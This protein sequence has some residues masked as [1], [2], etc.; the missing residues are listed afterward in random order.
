[1]G[2]VLR[3]VL[4]MMGTQP[5]VQTSFDNFEGI[6]QNTSWKM[7]SQSTPWVKYTE[8][9]VAERIIQVLLYAGS[10]TFLQ[11]MNYTTIVMNP[12]FLIAQ[13][14]NEGLVTY[15]LFIIEVMATQATHF[16]SNGGDDFIIVRP[17]LWTITLHE[18][19]HSF[20]TFEELTVYGH[21][22]FCQYYA[23]VINYHAS[24]KKSLK[25][26]GVYSHMTV[27]SSSHSIQYMVRYGPSETFVVKAFFDILTADTKETKEYKGDVANNPSQVFM[28]L[29][30]DVTKE[31]YSFLHVLVVKY[32]KLV[33]RYAT[34]TN[35]VI[36]FY[37]GPGLLSKP[38]KHTKGTFAC[39][40]F[41]CNVLVISRYNTNTSPKLS[42]HPFSDVTNWKEILLTKP[43]Q[44]YRWRLEPKQQ[45]QNHVVASVEGLSDSHLNASV[46]NV[47]YKGQYHPE[48]LF[49]GLS[50]FDGNHE[51]NTFVDR[52]CT[53]PNNYFLKNLYAGQQMIIVVHRHA[54]Y[55]SM[56]FVIVLS[57]T[58]CL[59]VKLNLCT[60]Q[61][62]NLAVQ[63]S[64]PFSFLGSM[65]S[66]NKKL[67]VKQMIDLQGM[68]CTII[69]IFV[70]VINNCDNL[71]GI[72]NFNFVQFRK[73]LK[74]RQT[75]LNFES[76]IFL[77]NTIS[78]FVNCYGHGVLVSRSKLHLAHTIDDESQ[79]HIGSHN[80]NYQKSMFLSVVEWK[81]GQ[82]SQY[83]G[84]KYMVKEHKVFG[85]QD[86]LHF[87]PHSHLMPQ[88]G[89]ELLF[90]TQF[91]SFIN[92]DY[93][94][95]L[96]F[97]KMIGQYSWI[98]IHIESFK[99]E[100]K[101]I[102][103]TDAP[104]SLPRL[105][106]EETLIFSLQNILEGDEQ[107]LLHISMAMQVKLALLHHKTHDKSGTE[108]PAIMLIF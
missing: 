63:T 9:L 38:Y 95:P 30:H 10:K 16:S 69:N 42:F 68:S 1:M 58:T 86:Y 60:S 50:I 77:K 81:D 108:G 25:F 99:P 51:M 33:L 92:T 19:L 15:P 97:V 18:T 48:C 85:S 75:I 64:D 45:I 12:Q 27:Y 14:H 105:P 39:S 11:M 31:I 91:L 37:D 76:F 74:S 96:Y 80:Q 73:M 93:K 98:D 40:S 4:F 100:D 26:C 46:Q 34:A 104:L 103:V 65:Q 52:I 21:M 53:F 88:Y 61:F 35:N 107:L 43:D 49:S 59:L 5:C 29:V 7:S 2:L 106:Y 44:L 89:A 47:T 17:P 101:V 20:I 57:M 62:D 32:K 83:F 36:V 70:Q 94:S 71:P 82:K 8:A 66:M 6:L 24:G 72:E 54:E 13:V 3:V 84:N 87:L 78:S 90:H 41:Q 79:F 67:D 28:I 56:K 102:N 55:A 22:R 23:V